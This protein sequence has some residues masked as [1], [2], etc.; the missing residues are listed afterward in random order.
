M[1]KMIYC[2]TTENLRCKLIEQFA[3][4]FS[5][6]NVQ[7]FLF[8]IIRGT[9]SVVGVVCLPSRRSFKYFWEGTPLRKI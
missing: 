3:K 7:T 1:L 8:L 6:V 2:R 5:S 4:A 9:N